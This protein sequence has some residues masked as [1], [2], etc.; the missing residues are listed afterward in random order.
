MGKRL[1]YL[2]IISV[3]IYCHCAHP[4]I[5]HTAQTVPLHK[6]SFSIEASGQENHTTVVLDNG[7]RITGNSGGR[8]FLDT[9]G[10][11]GLGRNLDIGVRFGQ[12]EFGA[13]MRY[14]FLREDRSWPSFAVDGGGG[15]NYGY[16]SFITSK[17]FPIGRWMITPLLNVN[18]KYSRGNFSLP[19]PERYRT[20]YG[21]EMNQV[22]ASWDEEERYMEFPVGVEALWPVGRI[23]MGFDAVVD[24]LYYFAKYHGISG[25]WNCNNKIISF[26]HTQDIIYIFQFKVDA[27]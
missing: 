4:P 3:L 20:S 11:F 8:G 24:P 13:D 21:V 26:S 7:D 22:A 5:I 14:A 19:L 9:E 17:N 23:H 12:L 1:T 2:G 27:F 16:V 15:L 6:F 18:V 25:C 10:R